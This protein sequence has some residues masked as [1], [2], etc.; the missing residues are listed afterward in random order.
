MEG[1][2]KGWWGRRLTRRGCTYIAYAPFT[3]CVSPAEPDCWLPPL[4]PPPIRQDLVL[5]YSDPTPSSDGDF[6]AHKAAWVFH[7]PPRTRHVFAETPSIHSLASDCGRDVRAVSQCRS[8]LP[9]PVR[10]T[11]RLKRK[12]LNL[13]APRNPARTSTFP[14]KTQKDILVPVTAFTRF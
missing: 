8:V 12:K 10:F 14:H 7:Y 3:M 11:V 4:L 9:P 2:R 1:E 5:F 13:I 6:T